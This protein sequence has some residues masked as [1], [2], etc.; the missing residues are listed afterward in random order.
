VRSLQLTARLARR[1]HF[2]KGM[3]TKMLRVVI[4]GDSLAAGA[5]DETGRG[6]RGRL[7]DEL[8]RYGIT[9]YEIVTL[10][11]VG[12]IT[13]ELLRRLDDPSVRTLIGGADVV[14]LSIGGNDMF[15]TWRSRRRTLRQPLRSGELLLDRLERVIEKLHE[16]NPDVAVHYI[17][18]YNPVG[19]AGVGPLFAKYLA[20]WD[21]SLARRF[22]RRPRMNIVRMLDVVTR[23]RLSRIDGFHPGA[24]AYR[25]AARRI[26]ERIGTA[27]R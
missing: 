14:V 16:I 17:S 24:A 22:A 5:G 27:G 4:L 12:E 2:A 11:I 9:A 19:I 18:T 3:G 26:A 10:G 1:W 20:R 23:S 25:I 7:E 6:L 15:K 21:R 13:H 8:F